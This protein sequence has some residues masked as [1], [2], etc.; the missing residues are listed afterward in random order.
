M[1]QPPAER[2]FQKLVDDISNLFLNARAAQVRF[3]WETGKRIVEEE[4]N[5]Q[6]RAAYG[7]RL[8][9]ELS[10]ALSAKHGPGFSQQTLHKMRHFYEENPIF[11]TPGKLGW[12]DYVELMPVKDEKKRRLLEQRI[13]KEGLKSREIRQ[14]VR[15]LRRETEPK[16]ITV[17][18]QKNLPPLKR[19]A[20]LALHTFGL[21]ALDGVKV[22]DGQ[23]LV[24]CGFFAYRPVPQSTFKSLNIVEKMSYT[25][26]AMV[27]RVVDG[28]TILV[29]VEVGL[30]NLLKER[31]RLRGIDCPEVSTPEGKRA[32]KFVEN[33]L[34]V[35]AR[36]VIHTQKTKTDIHGRFVADLFFGEGDVS[37]KFLLT[38]GI[39]LNQLLLDEGLAERKEW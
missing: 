15:R 3:A 35:G 10:G 17:K 23:T 27:N 37:D 20:D 32:K 33:L 38:E 26:A 2:R 29:A 31:L 11:P 24:D 39:Y 18:P 4:Q 21:A 16:T 7:A 28:D 9:P 6:M 25:Y 14:E 1:P 13:L 22:K 36:V 30:G 34:P 8:I 5:G 19:P 12:N